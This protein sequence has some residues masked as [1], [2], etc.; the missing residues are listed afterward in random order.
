MG[1]DVYERIYRL[2]VSDDFDTAAFCLYMEGFRDYHLAKIPVG[3]FT[4]LALHVA[5]A[6]SDAVTCQEVVYKLFEG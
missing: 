4:G 3:D 5:A 6:Y 2:L 1:E